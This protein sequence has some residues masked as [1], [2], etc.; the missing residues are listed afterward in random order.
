M[1]TFAGASSSESELDELAAFL[2]AAPVAGF[3]AAA[4]AGI[5]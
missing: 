4:F 1:D 3:A 5:F 2:G